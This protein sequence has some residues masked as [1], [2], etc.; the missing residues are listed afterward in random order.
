MQEVHVL[1][2][3]VSVIRTVS[4]SKDFYSNNDIY[5]NIRD[6][7]CDGLTDDKTVVSCDYV[8]G[9]VTVV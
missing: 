4:V 7:I 1:T 5:E 2:L 3:T 8:K 9:C 6:T